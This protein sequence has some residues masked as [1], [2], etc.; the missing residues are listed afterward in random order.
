M[1]I[2]VNQD[3]LRSFVNRSDGCQT[4]FVVALFFMSRYN[5]RNG[6]RLAFYSYADIVKGTGALSR[7]VRLSVERLTRIGFLL[8]KLKSNSSSVFVYALNPCIPHK[9]GT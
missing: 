9:S 5:F 1:W 4:D 8:A 7:S 6:N 3:A 2:P